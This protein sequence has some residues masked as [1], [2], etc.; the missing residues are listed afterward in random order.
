MQVSYSFCDRKRQ[1]SFPGTRKPPKSLS[2]LVKVQR[3]DTSLSLS[4]SAL[5]VTDFCTQPLRFLRLYYPFLHYRKLRRPEV[6]IVASGDVL[7][8][9]STVP[10]ACSASSSRLPSAS[11]MILQPTRQ[12]HTHMCVCV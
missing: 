9:E 11:A 6:G 7:S 10:P 8:V 1:T 4:L 12:L 5:S 2:K 3:L